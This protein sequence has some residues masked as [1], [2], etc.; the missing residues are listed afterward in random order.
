[1]ISWQNLYTKLHKLSL[2]FF[3]SFKFPLGLPPVCASGEQSANVLLNIFSRIAPPPYL[4]AGWIR[5]C[6]YDTTNNNIFV[7]VCVL[8]CIFI[9]LTMIFFLCE[10]YI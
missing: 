8:G 10:K 2:K 1:M 7:C 4:A 5:P 3:F 9:N 6:V